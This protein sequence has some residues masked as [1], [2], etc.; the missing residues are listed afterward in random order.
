MRLCSVYGPNDN[1]ILFYDNLNKFLLFHSDCPVILGGDWNTTYCNTHPPN[2][3][4]TINMASIPSKTRSDW[5]LDLCD[6]HNLVDPYRALY[7]TK[8]EFSFF[9]RG[10]RKHR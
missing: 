3:P 10:L 6:R 4:D 5:L 1:N 7:P 2:N 9:T 8:K